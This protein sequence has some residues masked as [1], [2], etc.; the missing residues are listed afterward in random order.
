MEISI[1][2]QIASL[3]PQ[4]RLVSLEAAVEI[5]P[6]PVGLLEEIETNS[7]GIAKRPMEEI[8]DIPAIAASRRAYKTMGKAPSRYRLSAEA[9]RRRIVKGGALYQIS[10]VVESINLTSLNSGFS[11]GGYDADKIEGNIDLSLGRADDVYEAIGRGQLNIE[12]LPVFRDSE[13]AFGSPTSDSVRTCI[14]ETTGRILLIFLD[15]ESDETV[16]EAVSLCERLLRTH[17]Q[18]SELRQHSISAS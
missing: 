14:T 15:F 8:K 10:N 7:L 13:G 2:A 18:A 12:N 4:L 17:C 3:C 1:N 6:S 11:I 9:L 5:K 16:F